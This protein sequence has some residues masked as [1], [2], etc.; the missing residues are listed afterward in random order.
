MTFANLAD[1]MNFDW[2]L[3]F[4]KYIQLILNK[5][6]WISEG[7]SYFTQNNVQQ[8]PH[9]SVPQQ[10]TTDAQSQEYFDTEYQDPNL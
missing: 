4:L 2:G 1:K 7:G 9:Q 6:W 8:P 10:S 3:N 5:F